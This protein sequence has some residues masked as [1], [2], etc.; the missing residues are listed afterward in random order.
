[1]TTNEIINQMIFLSKTRSEKTGSVTVEPDALIDAE[2]LQGYEGKFVWMLYDCGTFL[3]TEGTKRDSYSVEGFGHKW[4]GETFY[5]YDGRELTD[6]TRQ[7]A[8]AIMYK[9]ILKTI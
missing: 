7:Q 6:I 2:S 4:N 3:V 8:L 9:R 5:Y 1:M